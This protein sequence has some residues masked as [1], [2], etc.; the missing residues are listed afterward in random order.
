MGAS[1]EGR[2][3]SVRRLIG[4]FEKMALRLQ[5]TW[6]AVLLVYS[7]KK[8]EVS[9]IYINRKLTYPRQTVYF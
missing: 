7:G 4:L 5:M 6:H 3:M 8:E 9:Y 2:A 1:K